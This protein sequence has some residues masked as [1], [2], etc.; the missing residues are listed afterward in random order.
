MTNFFNEL[1]N[2]NVY[3]VATAYVVT[4]WLILQAVETLGNNL[5]WPPAIAYWTTLLLIVGFPIALVLTWLY[6]FTPQGLKRTGSVQQDTAD[7]RKAGRRLNHIIIGVLAVALCFLLV[8]RVFF[9]GATG[10]NKK[11]EASIAVLPFDFQ[12]TDK[13]LAFMSDAFSGAISDR[14]GQVAG[15]TVTSKTSS[16]QFKENGSDP[17]EI[18]RNLNVNYLIEGDLQFENNRIRLRARLI[19]A[20]NGY[21]RWNIQ[22]D[23]EF[24]SI[25]DIEEDLAKKVVNELRIEVFPNESLQLSKKISESSE[26]YKLYLRALELGKQRT[27]ETMGKA[28][29]LIQEA[30]ILEPNFAKAH[31]E[32][33]TLYLNRHAYG[34][35]PEDEMLEKMKYH[36]QK[37]KDIDSELPEVYYAE[38]RVAEIIQKDTSKAISSVRKAVELKPSYSEAYY[39]LSRWMWSIDKEAGMNLRIKAYELDPYNEFLAAM[40]AQNYKGLRKDEKKAMEILNKVLEKDPSANW[41]SRIKSAF[42]AAAPNGDFSSAFITLHKAMKDDQYEAVHLGWAI[43]YCIELDLKPLA[44]KYLNLRDLKYP[45]NR[46]S[47]YKRY[48]FNSFRK[49]Y[50]SNVDL[51]NIWSSERGLPESERVLYL[52]FTYFDLGQ[53]ERAK[54]IL[55]EG[56]PQLA[57]QIANLK[58]TDS[59]PFREFEDEIAFYIDIYRALGNDI[60]ADILAD[61]SCEYYDKLIVER[62]IVDDYPKDNFKMFCYYNKNDVDG[63]ITLLN[64]IYFTDK[65]RLPAFVFSQIQQN[66]FKPFEEDQRFKLF[67]EKVTEETH[68][69][70]AEVIEYLKS[71]GDWN[72]VWDEELGLE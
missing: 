32:L 25:M 44:E 60:I 1:K 52:S 53:L 64:K 62:S 63:V 41:C 49:D 46:N 36:F 13:S 71:A 3:K 70:R 43:D 27:D 33:V 5:G 47:F 61:K 29:D 37:A 34:E 58:P 59:L 55:E 28:I 6:E 42:L 57:R 68:R 54:K 10:I 18:G 69:M 17:R 30:L 19:N 7:N 24:S 45:N 15:L 4:S 2:R 16:S 14:L 51:I 12:S 9:A 11:Q 21:V 56:H 23:E 65:A 50:Q 48:Y 66:Y 40:I 38:S 20:S 8:E 67:A 22:Y 72:P 39:A 26:A 31:A 35:M